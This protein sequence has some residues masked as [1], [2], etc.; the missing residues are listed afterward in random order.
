MNKIIFIST[1]RRLNVSLFDRQKAVGM[2]YDETNA[3]NDAKQL[4]EQIMNIYRP[5]NHL[6]ETRSLKDRQ[7]SG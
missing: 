1:V 5:K 6:N 7:H 3:C 2:V 4:D